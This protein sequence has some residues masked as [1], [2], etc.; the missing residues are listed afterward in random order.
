MKRCGAVVL[1][2]SMLITGCAKEEDHILTDVP[3][4][5]KKNIHDMVSVDAAIY[6]KPQN[7]PYSTYRMK[8]KNKYDVDSLN[9]YFFDAE[10]PNINLNEDTPKKGVYELSMRGN[11]KRLYINGYFIYSTDYY[12]EKFSLIEMLKAEGMGFIPIEFDQYPT[13][14]ELDSFSREEAMR[15]AEEALK[16]IEY[17][18][19]PDPVICEGI[20]P[21]CLEPIKNSPEYQEYYK[22]YNQKPPEYTKD[23]E[24]YYMVY[25]PQ[26]DGNKLS[27]DNYRKDITNLPSSSEYGSYAVVCVGKS[28]IYNISTRY[29]YQMLPDSA[30]EPE[31]V[32]SF[33]D[34]FSK[35]TEYLDRFIFK[36]K[37]TIQKISFEYLAVRQTDGTVI[38][39]PAW[40]AYAEEAKEPRYGMLVLI[41]ALTGEY[42]LQ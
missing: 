34:A 12:D 1:L 7:M 9:Q 16:M 28:G 19:A 8:T 11:G 37:V 21:D 42:I 22:T 20:T 14:E 25:Q 41:D 23:D 33:E 26:I 5:I 27:L 30:S 18:Y 6:P 13:V 24:F 15:K 2:L 35:I 3:D 17:V 39:T 10:C 31:K 38:A 36:N 4:H 32:I 40:I 29:N